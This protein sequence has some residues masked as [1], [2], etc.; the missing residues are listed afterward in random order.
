MATKRK[1]T[2]TCKNGKPCAAWAAP[3]TNPPR[4][5]R[6][7]VTKTAP[8]KKKVGAPKGNQNAVKHGGYSGTLPPDLDAR[9]AALDRR[10]QHVENY[11]DIN[12]DT[13]TPEEYIKFANLQSQIASRLGRLMRGRA[14]DDDAA[15]KAEIDIDAV[16]QVLS[17]NF[18]IDLTGEKKE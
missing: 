12:A 18:N 7:P 17:T 10:L 8:V 14:N 3:E 1:C 5:W 4:C 6:H 15:T 13:L 11:L 16:L 2:G 9:I